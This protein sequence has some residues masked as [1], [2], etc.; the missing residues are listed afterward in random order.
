M[1]TDSPIPAARPIRRV[2]V[3][4][5]GEIATRIF[6]TC[7]ES[8]YGSVAVYTES[9]RRWPFVRA[10]ESAVRIDDYLD[11]AAIVDAA[12]RAG[13]DAIHPGYGFLSENA[14]FAEMVVS[15]GLIWVGP[16][17]A[18]IRAMGSKAEARRAMA[19]RGVPVVP[20][21]DG[22][23]QDDARFIEAAAEIG[24]PVLVKASAG[25]GG[26]GMQVVRS[27][28]ALVPALDAARR[29]A[30]G[31]FGDERLILER[32]L[33]RPRHIEVQ[34]LGDHHGALIHVFERECSLQ[35]RH[36][37]VIEEVPS[38]AFAGE[39]GELRRARL[40]EDALRAAAAVGY[41]NAGTV[42]F[43]VDE[44]GRHYFLEMN[45]R[46]QVE[47]AVT[48]GVI[49]DDL[50]LMQLQIAEGKPLTLR[51]DAL[52]CFGYAIEARLYAEDPDQGFLPQAG[53]VTVWEADPFAARFDAGVEAGTVVSTRYD[54]LLAKVI[55]WGP[56]RASAIRSLRHALSD[57]R[58]LGL[59]T[60]R[61]W[62]GRVLG[63]PDFAA[64]ELHTGFFDEHAAD[65]RPDTTPAVA[66]ALAALIDQIL[67]GRQAPPAGARLLPGLR[68]GWR[69]DLWPAVPFRVELDGE[70]G[71]L[72]LRDAPDL[73]SPDV[74]AAFR[75]LPSRYTGARGTVGLQDPASPAAFPF[76]AVALG[77]LQIRVFAVTQVQGGRR[78][79][80]ELDGRLVPFTVAARPG[81][82]V[83]VQTADRTAVVRLLPDLE[84]PG[85]AAHAAGS[86]AA[87]MPG[88]VVRLCVSVGQA[89]RAGEALVLLEAMK[90][91]HAVKAPAAGV[92]SALLCAEGQQV[93]SGQPLLVL[94]AVD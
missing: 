42:E 52:D 23:D 93:E 55:S 3:A 5:R 18:V 39:D 27:E 76:E 66:H 51:N 94:D 13:A 70:V 65:L 41:T 67:A 4:N 30:R 31:A 20:G 32:Y 87:P 89:V 45:T 90:M 75:L 37:K 79:E 35:R 88:R 80:L 24:Y 14:D 26:K 16:T 43:I 63:H 62:L 6:R 10:A 85:A 7:R 56:D 78:L 82:P 1:S 58:V 44:A 8:G 53:T 29:L 77:G 73:A 36:Q 28:E 69:G 84:P 50:V 46:L 68:P 33:E 74:V 91:E 11:G 86:L 83:F 9:D 40:L 71:L 48:E 19:A 34:V 59:R 60:N 61:E 38:P 47:H 17:P 81:G 54:P 49:Q 92:V 12:K 22:A 15:A 25:G 72:H 2:L 64:G 57:T 21:Y